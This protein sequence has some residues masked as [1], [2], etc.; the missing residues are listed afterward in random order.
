MRPS[1][2]PATIPS[3]MYS[4]DAISPYAIA[5]SAGASRTRSKPRS[6]RAISAILLRSR[7]NRATPSTTNSA[8]RTYPTTPPPAAAVRTRSATPIADEQQREDGHRNRVRLH[9]GSAVGDQHAAA[10][11]LQDVVDGLPEDRR[12]PRRELTT[13]RPENDDLGV[14][15]VGLGDDRRPGGVRSI[16]ARQNADA[17]RVADRDRLVELARWRRPRAPEADRSALGRAGPRARSARR[18]ARAAR[19]RAG[20]R[21][22]SRRPTPARGSRGR[23]DPGIRGREQARAPAAPSRS[24]AAG[25][26]GC[27]AGT[28]RIPPD[29]RASTPARPSA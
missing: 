22:P 5:K 1:A 26:A 13:R 12:L 27:A 16:E 7:V 17:V 2:A 20:M 15:R 19:S 29:P 24:R 14:P 18:S 28:R 4:D 21:R 8:P 10:R 23:A 9:A 6:L 3:A 25:G 11:V